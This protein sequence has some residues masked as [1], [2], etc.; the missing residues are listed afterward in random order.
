LRY[1]QRIIA[2]VTPYAIVPTTSGPPIAAPIPMSLPW[3][4]LPNSTAT[5]VTTLSGSAVPAAARIVPT[6]MGPN[7]SRTPSH[8]TAFTNHSHAR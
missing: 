5:R 7:L 4:L 2:P 1:R 8:S 6:A 3:S